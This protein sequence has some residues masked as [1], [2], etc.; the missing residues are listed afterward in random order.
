MRKVIRIVLDGLLR[1][2]LWLYYKSRTVRIFLRARLSPKARVLDIGS[3]HNPWFRSNV[4]VDRFVDDVTERGAPLKKAGK[5][6][7]EADATDLPFPAKSFDFV[8]C[9]HVAEHIGDIAKFFREIQRVGKAGYIETPNYLLEQMV[10]TTTHTWALWVENGVLHAEK[11]WVAGAPAR[12]YHTMHGLI[13]K[14]PV[15]AF[16]L[17]LLPEF[18]V[19]Q[20]WWKDSFQF[21]LHEAPA[22]SLPTKSAASSGTTCQ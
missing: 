7:V 4:L 13:G 14:H 8:Y 2:P 10:G 11:K 22:P 17:L 3:G 16:A 1:L 20:F 12:V 5:E 18:D 6:F 21:E 19:M 15:F 9:S